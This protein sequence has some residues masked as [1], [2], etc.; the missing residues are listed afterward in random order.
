[1]H[2]GTLKAET[3]VF[4][5]LSV[6]EQGGVV[7]EFCFFFFLL[8]IFFFVWMGNFSL[9]TCYASCS[10]HMRI[11][12]M[13]FR[14]AFQTLVGTSFPGLHN[15]LGPQMFTITPISK[16]HFYLCWQPECLCL[17]C[18]NNVNQGSWSAVVR[19]IKMLFLSLTSTTGGL[20]LMLR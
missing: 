17:I 2:R 8:L 12:C 18:Y 7:W 15:S 14:R 5:S 11:F 1:M 3:W 9:I 16:T 19:G 20:D 6:M 10:L 4:V 13:G